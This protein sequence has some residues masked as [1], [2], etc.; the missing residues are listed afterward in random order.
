M[1]KI[2]LLT[3][4]LAITGLSYGQ[5]S[6]V[7]Y[8]ETSNTNNAVNEDCT[9]DFTG[10][11]QQLAN[12]ISMAEGYSV[13]NDFV[14]APGSTLTLESFDA[15]LLPFAQS[16][17]DIEEGTVTI[18]EDTNGNGPGDVVAS[19]IVFQTGESVDPGDFAGY[20][21]WNIS[22]EF[23]AEITLSN[24]GTD[25]ARYWLGLTVESASGQLVYWVG[26][27]WNQNTNNTEYNYQ[28]TDG[29]NTFEPIDTE[30]M[31]GARFDSQWVLYGQCDALGVN[32]NMLSQVS[33]Y[34]NPTTG[35][36]NVQTPSNV[37]VTSVAL[38]DI[39]GKQVS[40]DFSDSTINMSSLSQG[41]Y[42]LKVETSAGTL[43]QKIVK[44]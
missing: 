13:A 8:A 34:P 22:Y 4:G 21:M 43:T 33:V 39:L 1:K 23:D 5:A 14:V 44:Q 40:A 24:N 12:A 38:F 7:G 20:T 41:V 25:D 17:V 2:T 37:D 19:S 27:E 10:G 28:S 15:L 36:L 16:P 42:L 31:P 11:P 30:S 18:Y 6:L 35:I 29:G 9:Q 26:Y 32:N 3:L